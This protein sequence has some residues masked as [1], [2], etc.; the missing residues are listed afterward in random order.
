MK[1]CADCGKEI[2]ENEKSR[3][4]IDQE[5]DRCLICEECLKKYNIF[6]MSNNE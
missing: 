1:K 5:G 2:G 6:G 4:A 3:G